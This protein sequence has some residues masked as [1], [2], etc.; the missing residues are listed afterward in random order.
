MG[1]GED[2]QVPAGAASVHWTR[3]SEGRKTGTTMTTKH[4]TKTKSRR[5]A[6][7]KP[8]QSTKRI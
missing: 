8:V 5:Q 3:T 2:E 6:A 1:V 7:T 4:P